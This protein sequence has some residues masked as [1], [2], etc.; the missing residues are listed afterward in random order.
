MVKGGTGVLTLSTPKTYTGSTT[1]DAGV[2]TVSS[3]GTLSGTSGLSVASARPST[4][5]RPPSD[6]P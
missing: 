5:C 1:V 3:T 4:T 6:L 2:M